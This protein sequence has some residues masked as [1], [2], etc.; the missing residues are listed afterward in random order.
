M[1]PNCGLRNFWKVNTEICTSH[2]G[3]TNLV[4]QWKKES[5][6]LKFIGLNLQQGSVLREFSSRL[7]LDRTH[8]SYHSQM[9]WHYK[10][11]MATKNML[12]VNSPVSYWL[13]NTTL[14]IR[15]TRCC[16]N[17]WRSPKNSSSFNFLFDFCSSSLKVKYENTLLDARAPIVFS[18]FFKNFICEWDWLFLLGS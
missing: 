4:Y 8:R 2:R 3:L 5:V 9:K 10:I 11:T 16:W 7:L 13:L 14:T 17:H 18:S 6:R 1:T 15:V 12:F